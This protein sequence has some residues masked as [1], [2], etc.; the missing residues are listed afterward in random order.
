MRDILPSKLFSWI[1][2]KQ[3]F[4][5]VRRKCDLHSP[6]CSKIFLVLFRNLFPVFLNE[7]ICLFGVARSINEFKKSFCRLRNINRNWRISSGMWFIQSVIFWIDWLC[8]RSVAHLWTMFHIEVHLTP[9]TS[10]GVILCDSGGIQW[11]CISVKNWI[12]GRCVAHG[13]SF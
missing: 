1:K 9:Q 10:V 8:N 4:V 12:C 11:S 13:T 6:P 7:F 3:F 2:K 5:A